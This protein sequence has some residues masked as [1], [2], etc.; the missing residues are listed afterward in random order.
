MWEGLQSVRMHD[1]DRDSCNNSDVGEGGRFLNIETMTICLKR[2]KY[3]PPLPQLAN[4]RLTIR[5][6]YVWA[7]LP[8]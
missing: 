3:T 1:S 6:V 7:S 2:G 8:L 4:T 5:D